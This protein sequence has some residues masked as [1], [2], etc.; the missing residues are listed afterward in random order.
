MSSFLVN[1][2]PALSVSGPTQAATCPGE[3][4]FSGEPPPCPLL[5]L[6]A[7]PLSIRIRGRG[8]RRGGGELL[9]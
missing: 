7:L 8:R 4:D 5:L 1:L 9:L 3:L 2:S 6:P